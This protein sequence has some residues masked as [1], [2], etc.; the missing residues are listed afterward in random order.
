MVDRAKFKYFT[1]RADLTLGD[2]AKHLGVNPATLTRKNERTKRFTRKRFEDPELLNMSVEESEAV[3]VTKLHKRKAK[4][5]T[6]TGKITVKDAAKRMATRDRTLG[7]KRKFSH[8]LQ[9]KNRWKY[10]FFPKKFEELM[11]GGEKQC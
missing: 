11:G 4:E 7:L 10:T 6:H 9:M 5:R 1:M 3:L 2:V 8:G